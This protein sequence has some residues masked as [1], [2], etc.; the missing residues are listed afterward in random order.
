MHMYMYM[1]MYTRYV[2]K[3]KGSYIFAA[4]PCIFA[5]FVIH[6]LVPLN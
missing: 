3:P 6:F 5:K 4:E 1:C 2:F